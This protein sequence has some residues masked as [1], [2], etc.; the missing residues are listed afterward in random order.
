MPRAASLGWLATMNGGKSMK[1]IL[2]AASQALLALFCL[3]MAS[4]A[5][6]GSLDDVMNADRAFAAAALRDGTRAAFV[7]YAAPDAM[8]F[9]DGVSPIRGQA[10]IA[11][12]FR[13][14]GG[15]VLEW[16]PEGGEVAASG[17]LGYTWGNFHWKAGD[18]KQGSGNYVSIWRRMDGDWKWIVDL[19]VDAPRKAE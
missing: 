1:K 13:R 12:S 2:V 3:G 10:A 8:I 4:V 18:G 15:V 16:A 19:G 14:T 6:G 11:A 9:R 17:D 7:A 5:R